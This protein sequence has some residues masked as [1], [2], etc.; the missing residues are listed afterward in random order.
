MT[1]HPTTYHCTAAQ[2][3]CAR[4]GAPITQQHTYRG[5]PRRPGWRHTRPGHNHQATHYLPGC[6]TTNWP[7]TTPDTA[8]ATV[9]A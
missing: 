6:P 1:R 8:P 2:H 5:G 9:V 4:C 3:R 7:T